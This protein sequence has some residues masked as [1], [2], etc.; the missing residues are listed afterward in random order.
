MKYTDDASGETFVK[1]FE[2]RLFTQKVM[3]WAEIKR[4]AATNPAW[5]WHRPD[6]LDRLKADCLHREVWREN[7]GYVEKGPFPQP[8][9]AVKLQELSRDEDTGLARLRVTPVNADTIYVEIG[10]PATTAS[11]KLS[12][13]DYATDE[14]VV[15]FLAVD[16]TGVHA[17]GEP[18]TWNNRITLQAWV[19]GSAD[20]RMVELRAAQRAPI[21]YSTDGSDPKAAGG[22]Y[23]DPFTVPAGSRLVLA[24][25]EDKGIVSDTHQIPIGAEPGP[26]TDEPRTPID[27]ERPATWRPLSHPER[28]FRFTTTHNTY[29][30]LARLGKH[31]GR[32]AA[33]RI[34]VLDGQWVDL[35]LADDLLLT[36]DQLR[37]TVEHLRSLVSEGEVNIEAAALWFPTGR[38]LLD[39]V[40]EIAVELPRNEV[41]P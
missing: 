16:A 10:V 31:A 6:A 26:D 3:P 24:V 37:A 21:R 5:Q 17:T 23:D 1:K 25:A 19:Y 2:A 38:Q 22:S 33:Q 12:G 4:R 9:T 7:G 35:Q 20:D 11:H 27:R 34:A 36:A 15:S 41:E 28:V 39:Y 8:A 30:F 32:A 29:G 18:L 13:R 40:H 14:L